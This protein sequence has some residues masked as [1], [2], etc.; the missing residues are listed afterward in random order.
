ME[1]LGLEPSENGITGNYCWMI[2]PGVAWNKWR[3]G[4]IG[5]S[6]FQNDLRRSYSP[7]STYMTQWAGMAG[8]EYGPGNSVAPVTSMSPFRDHMEGT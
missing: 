8:P 3:S 1:T 5:W 2:V 7:L 4:K 6:G